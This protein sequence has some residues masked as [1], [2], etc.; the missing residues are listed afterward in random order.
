MI[1]NERDGIDAFATR[2][3]PR[4]SRLGRKENTRIHDAKR[5]AHQRD[6]DSQRLDLALGLGA[7][8]LADKVGLAQQQIV[9]RAH[10]VFEGRVEVALLGNLLGAHHHHRTGVNR[11]RAHR[12][13]PK[14][15]ECVVGK[16]HARGFDDDALGA[17]A[18]PQKLQRVQ[19]VVGK[20]AAYAA[21]GEFHKVD[22]L[23]GDL[24]GYSGK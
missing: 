14:V 3:I 13:A 9:G 24:L 23:L 19:Q 5:G 1:A 11:P 8:V 18:L 21:A 17:G 15:K 20:A 6:I 16:G 12:V 4:R 22:A 10:L 2:R 7:F